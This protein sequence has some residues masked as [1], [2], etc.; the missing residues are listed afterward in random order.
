MRTILNKLIKSIRSGKS[1][2]FCH[3]PIEKGEMYYRQFNEND[4]GKVYTFRTHEKC[5]KIANKLDMF[6]QCPDGLSDTEFEEFIHDAYLDINPHEEKY[7]S[8]EKQLEFVC[9]KH[10]I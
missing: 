1:C 7:P 9:N 6:R 8:F 3:G 10:L 2:D 5:M 4:N